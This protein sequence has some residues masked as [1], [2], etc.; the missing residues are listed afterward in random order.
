VRGYGEPQLAVPK[1]FSSTLPE[2]GGVLRR[3]RTRSGRDGAGKGGRAGEEPKSSWPSAVDAVE[4]AGELGA[5]DRDRGSLVPSCA[6]AAG[7]REVVGFGDD[8]FAGSCRT[9]R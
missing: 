1:R 8:V 7:G 9:E 3:P 4:K 5:G 2:G 6:S